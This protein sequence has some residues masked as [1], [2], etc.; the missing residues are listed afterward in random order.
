M[1]ERNKTLQLTTAYSPLEQFA[2]IPL[3]PIH[4]G[5]L[6]ILFINSSLSM[7]PTISLILLLVHL[8]I[9][10]GGHLVPNAW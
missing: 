7:P 10:N 1:S 9:L 2:I 4:I 6:Y 8:V 5:N 3:I